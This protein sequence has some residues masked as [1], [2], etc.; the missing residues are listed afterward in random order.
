MKNNF[1]E[2]NPRHK[3]IKTADFFCVRIF[4][5]HFSFDTLIFFFFLSIAAT[6]S[7]ICKIKVAVFFS[8]FLLL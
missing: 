4:W 3:N 7:P 6:L 2:Y 5:S 8:S 1:A